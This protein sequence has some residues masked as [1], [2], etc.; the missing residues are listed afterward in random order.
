MSVPIT[1]RVEQNL[2]DHLAKLSEHRQMTMN[3]LI[4]Q[5]LVQFVSKESLAVEEEL[6]ASLATLKAYRASDPNFE[7][8]IDGVVTAEL[9]TDVD[10]AQGDVVFPEDHEATTLVRNL[11]RA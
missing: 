11:L 3:K 4:T 2:K 8:A 10:P 7:Q 5:A 6:E 1:L 9:S